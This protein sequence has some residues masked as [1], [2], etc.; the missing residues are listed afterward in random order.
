MRLHPSIAAMFTIGLV[1]CAGCGGGAEKAPTVALAPKANEQPAKAANAPIEAGWGDVVGRIVWEGELPVAGLINLPGNAVCG[2]VKDETWLIDPK[3]KGLKNTFVWLEPLQKGQAIA[4]HPSL[5]K[6]AP[7]TVEVDQPACAFVPHAVALREGQVLVAK[8]TSAIS[9]NFKWTGSPVVNHGGNQLIAPTMSVPI[10]N[11]KADRLPI[12][13]E[14]NIHPWM[15][16]WIRVFDHPYF[17]VTDDQG[18]FELKNAPAG[19]FKMKIWN[20]SGGWAGGAAG[21]DGR[22]LTIR[23]GANALGD[24]AYPAPAN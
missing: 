20:A 9:H 6:I 5:V 4:V 17:A 13:V 2:P 22:P 11:L 23:S 1:W 12:M 24:I 14:C 16:G 19:D 7:A 21:K 3:T 15:K 10:G 8:N 18:R